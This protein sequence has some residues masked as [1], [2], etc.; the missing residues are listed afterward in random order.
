[1]GTPLNPDYV[2]SRAWMKKVT[3]TAHRQH[4]PPD[5]FDRDSL[6]AGLWN[7][8]RSQGE[9][10][11]DSHK[12]SSEIGSEHPAVKLYETCDVA[13]V[14]K[15]IAQNHLFQGAFGTLQNSEGGFDLVASET[16][17]LWRADLCLSSYFDTTDFLDLD[18]S[19]RCQQFL[20]WEEFFAWS[21]GPQDVQ[22][23]CRSS[24]LSQQMFVSGQVLPM[25]LTIL[26][27]RGSQMS[28]HDLHKFP[29]DE[30]MVTLRCQDGSI[31][32][33]RV[34][35]VGGFYMF[36]QEPRIVFD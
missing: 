36:Q 16:V 25:Y 26:G 24:I 5:V 3:G 27:C 6:V 23:S 14:W 15:N 10:S 32:S 28:D 1:M 11:W 22:L 33:V 18:S 19:I 12:Q 21:F 34:R 35:W 2:T 29:Q 4:P 9:F 31:A 30:I 7:A 13:V 17:E 20:T 8:R